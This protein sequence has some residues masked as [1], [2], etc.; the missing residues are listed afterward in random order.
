[1][2]L[3]QGARDQGEQDT[4]AN[5]LAPHWMVHF[6]AGDSLAAAGWFITYWFSHRIGI[7]DCP[8]A[9]IAVRLGATLY[10]FNMA[11]FQ[12]I[13]GQD[14]RLPYERSP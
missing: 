13:P 1:M 3:V 2:E 8:I 6:E 12:A 9:A 4:I 5:R 11:H 10:T 14:I 7:P